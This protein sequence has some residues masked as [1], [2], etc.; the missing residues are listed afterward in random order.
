M[1]KADYFTLIIE[2][3]VNQ[4]IDDQEHFF[5]YCTKVLPNMSMQALA[6]EL[7]HFESLAV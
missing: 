4:G 6:Y 7:E 5:E 3:M 1:T 2:H